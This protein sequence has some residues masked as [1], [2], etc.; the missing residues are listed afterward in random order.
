MKIF[1]VS[2]NFEFGL[3]LGLGFFVLGFKYLEF[4]YIF[5][6]L[7]FLNYFFFCWVIIIDDVVNCFNKGR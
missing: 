2:S 3:Y 5:N 6:V 7:F 4:C 1:F